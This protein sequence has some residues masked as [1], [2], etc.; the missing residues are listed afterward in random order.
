MSGGRYEGEE[1]APPLPQ[2]WYECTYLAKLIKNALRSRG[3]HCDVLP[4]GDHF[5][6]Y[7]DF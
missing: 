7:F 2:I 1:K 6:H 5:C 3:A 4:F